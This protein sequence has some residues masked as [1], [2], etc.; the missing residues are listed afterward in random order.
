[1][2][3]YP[4]ARQRTARSRDLRN[5]TSRKPAVTRPVSARIDSKIGIKASTRGKGTRANGKS[6]QKATNN[7]MATASA[8][9]RAPSGADA[10]T[11]NA[12]DASDALRSF[13]LLLRR[14]P[15]LAK[16][17]PKTP[18]P[19]RWQGSREARLVQQSLSRRPRIH[20]RN[21]ICHHRGAGPPRKTRSGSAE[22]TNP[23]EWLHAAK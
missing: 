3:R 14:S 6:A 10:V 4:L 2:K 7:P 13:T 11:R 19:S 23:A 20:D 15:K 18:S 9:R 8:R 1:I 22:E 21:T 16:P 17:S 12:S 5:T